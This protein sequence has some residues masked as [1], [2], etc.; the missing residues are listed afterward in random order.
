MPSR[1]A[2]INGAFAVGG[3][4]VGATLLAPFPPIVVLPILGALLLG[5]VAWGWKMRRDAT[6]L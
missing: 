6:K 5:A 4:V 1:N 2:I 3:I